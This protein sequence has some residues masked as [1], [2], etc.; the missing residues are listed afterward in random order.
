MNDLICFYEYCG[1]LPIKELSDEQRS[2]WIEAYE[3]SAFGALIEDCCEFILL[4]DLFG[5]L[6]RE[7]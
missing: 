5:C 6:D 7:L 3:Y 1:Y 4:Y 2:L